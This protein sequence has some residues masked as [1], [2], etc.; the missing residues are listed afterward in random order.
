[1]CAFFKGFSDAIPSEAE[2]YCAPFLKDFLMQFLL[3]QKKGLN[4]EY[5]WKWAVALATLS[6]PF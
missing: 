5:C 6:F 2:E 1:L 3:K 4:N